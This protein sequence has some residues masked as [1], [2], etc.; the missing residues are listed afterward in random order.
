MNMNEL[1]M[2]F[3]FILDPNQ[4]DINGRRIYCTF[5]L[6][7]YLLSTDIILIPLIFVSANSNAY[8]FYSSIHIT[9]I[10]DFNFNF[11]SN[12]LIECLILFLIFRGKSIVQILYQRVRIRTVEQ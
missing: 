3:I 5:F 12:C 10:S 6:I 7:V 2:I 1:E 8:G 4:I 9:I 11:N